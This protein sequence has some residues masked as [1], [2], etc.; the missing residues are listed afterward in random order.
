MERRAAWEYHD[1]ETVT[2]LLA[3]KK[4]LFWEIERVFTTYSPNAWDQQDQQS[5]NRIKELAEFMP[6]I[7][8][9][10]FDKYIDLDP[11]FVNKHGIHKKINK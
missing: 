2:K 11:F 8:G 3:A 9:D 5:K 4:W 6:D 1:F 7:C 10:P